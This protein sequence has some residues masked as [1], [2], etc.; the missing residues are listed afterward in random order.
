MLD[1]S[2]AFHW[3]IENNHS[4]GQKGFI[5]KTLCTLVGR[6]G[7]GSSLW[8]AAEKDPMSLIRRAFAEHEE[9]GLYTFPLFSAIL[10][11]GL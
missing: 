8:F 9:H 6:E 7:G 11:K 4:G 5:L 10:I 2:L 3:V 1:S